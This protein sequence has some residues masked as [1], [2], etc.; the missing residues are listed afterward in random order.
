M[1]TRLAL[2]LVLLVAIYWTVLF[3]AQRRLMYPAPPV[4]GAPPPPDDAAIVW[5]ESPAGRTEAWYLPPLTRAAGPAPLLLFA[6]GNAELI[7]YWPPAFEEPRRWGM[8]VLLVEYPGYGRSGGTPSR[9]SIQQVF[10]AALDWAGGQ[11]GIDAARIVAYGRSLG[12]GA[13]AALTATRRPAGLILESTFSNTTAFAWGMGAPPFLVRDRFDNL[14]AVRAYAGP[15]LIL[16]GRSDQIIPTSHGRRLAEAVGVPLQLMACGHND[17]PRPW[18][19]IRVFLE[20]SGLLPAARRA[21][22]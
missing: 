8:G 2:N 20:E 17:C 10:E 12:G 18:P 11:R 14:S 9:G 16:H 13:V 3:F 15:R 1:L 19:A 7:Q 5:L 6:H 21:P 22:G 4:D